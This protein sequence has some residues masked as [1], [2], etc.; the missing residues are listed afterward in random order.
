MARKSGVNI[1]T[2]RY[3]N[4]KGVDFS[5]DS[6]LVDN[7]RSPFAVNMI[8]DTGGMPEKRVGYRTLHSLNGKINGLFYGVFDD[9]VHMLA[10]CGDG[11]YKFTDDNLVEPISLISNISDTPST[12]I[13]FGGKLY[14]LT[15]K[16]YLI[17]DGACIKNVSE[18]AYIPT[19][20]IA[21]A[22]SG[23]GQAFEGINLIQ[24]KQKNEFIADGTSK[25]YQLS[26]TNLDDVPVKATINGNEKIEGDGFT[27]DKATGLVKFTTAPPA[28]LAGQEANVIIEFS[29]T[30]LGYK[31]KIA[32]CTIVSSFGVG[33]S[34]RLVF[35]GNSDIKNIDYISALNDP[36]YIPDNSYSVIGSEVSAIIGYLRIGEHLAVI[37][38]NTA[39]D[40]TVYLKSATLNNDG[41]AVFP[42]KQSIAGV[43]AISK[44]CFGNILDEQL[45]LSDSGI[46][47]LTTNSLTSERIIQNRSFF[48]DNKLLKEIGLENACSVSF[49]G[50]FMI[51][52]NE[53]VYILDGRQNKSYRAKS[54]SDFIYE[55]Y[56]WDSIDASV[57]M[58]VKNGSNE[59]L[60]FGTSD[61][62]IKKFNYDVISSDKYADD[63]QPITAIWSTKAD[64]DGDVSILKTMIK[65]G[66]SVTIKPY[67]RSSCKICFRTDKDPNYWEARYQKM[68]IF[69][70][71]D[72]D[73][74][75]FTFNTNDAPQEV[76]FNIK[77]KKYK[78]LQIIVKN[79]SLNEGFGIFGVTKHFVP[80]NFAK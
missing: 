26:S 18:N 3:T 39:E 79:D 77:I 31:D 23:G 50:T 51:C 65:K 27:V 48:I 25:D 9:E 57:F 13:S 21:R 67:V 49:N 78:R 76:G 30:I 2:T 55:C 8:A 11:I 60:Y 74:S 10:H 59:S 19:T 47:A 38:E 45:F 37:K 15:G 70:F 56:F 28:P 73:F 43:G 6:S 4:F 40:S 24:P 32:N 64:D 41:E 62:K 1:N 80:G 75:R 58:N 71:D 52:V 16:Q 34:D 22:P 69:N 5:T 54:Q 36:T 61:G 35:S 33:S 68:D 14:I 72:I 44:R 66:N 63:G 12:Y 17:Y 20:V 7:S 46:C 29:K 42:V 53:N